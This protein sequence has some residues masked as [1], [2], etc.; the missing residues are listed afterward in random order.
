MCYSITNYVVQSMQQASYDHSSTN[1]QYIL[2]KL[3]MAGDF[4]LVSY[5]KK[6]KVPRSQELHCCSLAVMR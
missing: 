1:L 5:L 2:N 6:K 3:E 4:Y